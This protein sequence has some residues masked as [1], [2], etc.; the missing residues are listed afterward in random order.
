MMPLIMI[1]NK[2][3]DFGYKIG[4]TGFWIWNTNNKEIM[5]ASDLEQYSQEIYNIYNSFVEAIE[6][7]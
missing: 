4:E 7:Q 6:K 1:D 3:V 2:I 5:L